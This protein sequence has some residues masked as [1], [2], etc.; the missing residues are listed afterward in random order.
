MRIVVEL[1][2]N[3]V[4]NVVLNQLYKQTPLQSSF[5]FNMLALVPALRDGQMIKGADGQAV[6]E[7]QVLS[8]RDMLLH[9]IAHRKVVIFRLK[10]YE[11]RKAQERA[12]LLEGFR[13]ALDNIDE[14]IEI[15][16]GSDTVDTARTRLSERFGLSEIQANAIVDMRLRTLTGLERQ[17][18][19]E[20]FAQLIKTIAELEDILASPRRILGIVKP[21]PRTSRSARD[22]RKTRRGAPRDVAIEDI[23][24]DTEV[25]VTVTVGGASTR[26]V[27]TFRAQNRGAAA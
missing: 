21:K 14:V 18:I 7:P 4:P 8:L 19:E 2:R 20:E 1:Q 26:S 22:E 13:I 9:F 10:T 27:D 11:L 17:K 6:L 12:H 3:A 5:A 15:V 25:V 24:A 16:R 23:I